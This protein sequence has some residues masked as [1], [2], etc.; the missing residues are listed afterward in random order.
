MPPSAGRLRLLQRLFFTANLRKD[1]GPQTRASRR[2]L[3]KDPGHRAAS[4]TRDADLGALPS[5]LYA[6]YVHQG[7]QQKQQQQQQQEQ[8]HVRDCTQA[9]SLR[10]ALDASQE[11]TKLRDKLKSSSSSNSSSSNSSSSLQH[12]H[13]EKSVRLLREGAP[14]AAGSRANEASGSS[15]FAI[16][17]SL[18]SKP[19]PKGSENRGEEPPPVHQPQALLRFGFEANLGEAASQQQTRESTEDPYVSLALR[20]AAFRGR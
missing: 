19:S 8:L 9:E 3:R 13:E 16:L 5:H 15:S 12:L 18:P 20:G 11:F 4:H 2:L 7:K 10:R 1:S 17:A 6:Q 14:V